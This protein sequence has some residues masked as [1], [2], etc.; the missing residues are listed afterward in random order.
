MKKLITI[1]FSLLFAH[2]VLAQQ[3]PQYSHDMFNLMGINPGFAG[4]KGDINFT[5][6]NRRQWMGF[7]GAPKTTLLTL[8]SS[9]SP[10]GLKGGLGL[11][12][13]NDII[14][15][16][17]NFNLKLSYSYHKQIRSGILGI[18][19]DAGLFNKSIDGDFNTTDPVANDLALPAKGEQKMLFD[20]GL[21]LFY[22]KNNFYAGLS[23]THISQPRAKFSTS[24]AT[25]LKRHYFF[26][27]GYNIQ[28]SNAL[29]DLTPSMLVKSDGISTQFNFN[30][31]VLYNKKFWGGVTY[32]NKDA[33]VALIGAEL[34]N[35]IK[36][37][38]AYDL[39]LS[40]IRKGSSGSHEVL[41]SY[42]FNLGIVRIPQKYK[43]VRFL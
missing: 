6:L 2:Q 14:G 5:T 28:L 9:L 16:E 1:L 35:G 21:G 13:V 30:V 33:I 24:G 26:I 15:F 12:I 29:I 7:E 23:S 40:K 42:S 18:G 31:V 17:K 8:E 22:T 4:I 11:S 19:I 10:I 27:T 41:L 39:I 20:L 37:G 36:L 32:R 3:D 43:S 34:F 25:F 38:Y